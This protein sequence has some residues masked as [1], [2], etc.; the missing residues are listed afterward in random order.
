MARKRVQKTVRVNRTADA[1]EVIHSYPAGM[2]VRPPGD[3]PQAVARPRPIKC[4]YCGAEGSAGV[5]RA[6]HK[7]RVVYYRC[8]KCVDTATGDFS[9]FQAV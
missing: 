5:E 8:L 1:V 3:P 6:S 4:P 7:G 2:S 9:I